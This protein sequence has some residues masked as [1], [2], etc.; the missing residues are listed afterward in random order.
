ME[1]AGLESLAQ[2]PELSNHMALKSVVGASESREVHTF[3]IGANGFTFWNGLQTGGG[4]RLIS[5]ASD[6]GLEALPRGQEC[7]ITYVCVMGFRMF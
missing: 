7:T 2:G 5:R 1:S 6:S 4:L 3:S